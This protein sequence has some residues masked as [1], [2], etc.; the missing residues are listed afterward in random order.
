MGVRAILRMRAGC[1]LAPAVRSLV[2]RPRNPDFCDTL[3]NRLAFWLFV[4]GLA[5]AWLEYTF[6]R[7]IAI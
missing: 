7:L 1:S 4:R 2:C 3:R 6:Y 5:E